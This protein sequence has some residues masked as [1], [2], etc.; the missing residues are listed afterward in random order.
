[1][2]PTLI[3]T[4][5]RSTPSLKDF[6]PP[7]TGEARRG[8]AGVGSLLLLILLVSSCTK[9][10]KDYD[11]YGSDGMTT[12]TEHLA[13]NLRTFVNKGTIIGQQYATVEG[14]GWQGDSARSDINEVSG[15][16]PAATSYELKGIERDKK[17]NS[18]GISFSLIR[19]DALQMFRHGGLVTMTWQAPEGS[20]ETIKE[21]AKK[22][23]AFIA[24]LRDDYLIHAPVI[25]YPLPTGLGNWYD[26]LP[27]DQYQELYKAVME[28]MKD[29]EV[30]NIVAGYAE[31]FTDGSPTMK[32]ALTGGKLFD[33]CPDEADIQPVIVNAI[34][35]Q[36]SAKAD[37]A[38]YAATL[39]RL[40]QAV[41]HSVQSRN[42]VPSLTTG[43]EGII[44]KNLYTKTILPV[45]KNNRLSYV[46]FSSNR[47]DFKNRH[48]AVP[49]PGI[50]NAII[51]DFVTFS[52]DRSTIFRN[53][54]N[55]VY[56]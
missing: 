10:K 54:L 5:L 33:R 27:A 41:A 23:A 9:S 2:K 22:V 38:T 51:N 43:I 26:R 47:G 44:A 28:V 8:L 20:V 7:I 30:P 15:L 42:L 24:N 14:I 29:E 18:D 49:Y 37:T 56:L 31:A 53:E 1:M 55:G 50:D 46:L 40:V 32:A 19:K 6:C 36:S 13:A 35:V 12:R 25:F 4:F 11:E 17:V 16:D 34:Y 3:H 52:N 39:P 48:F 45:I 21:E